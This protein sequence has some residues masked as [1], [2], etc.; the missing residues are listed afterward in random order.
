MIWI[1]LA[2]AVIYVYCRA[3]CAWAYDVR[4]YYGDI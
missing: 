4:D 2:A 1:T 3:I